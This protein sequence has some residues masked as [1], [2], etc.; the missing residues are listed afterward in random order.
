MKHARL[1]VLLSSLLM[2]AACS[3]GAHRDALRDQLV[4]N[5][6]WSSAIVSANQFDVAASWKTPVPGQGKTHPKTLF[7]YLEGD[8]LAY[9]RPNRASNNPTPDD[10]VGLRMAIADPHSGP[11]LYL[12][13]PCQYVIPDHGRNCARPYW[14]LQRYAPEIVDSLGTTLDIFKTR[15]AAENL[16]LVGYSGGGALAVILAAQRHDVV[17]IVTVA[18]NLDT[19]YWTG[20]DK[21]SPLAG[22]LDPADFATKLGNLPQVH[23][24][25]ANDTTVGPDVTR[26]FMA[27]LPKNTPV[28]AITVPDFTHFCCWARD[29]NQLSR[30]T[31]LSA[32]PGWQ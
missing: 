32:I 28:S 3:H 27:R 18:G 9:I 14:T 26:A 13:R 23:F 30:R 15:L 1:I 19:S 4:A 20:R 21:L 17:G 6:G 25:G 10:P 29:W 7:V 31:E 8:G 24:A 5:A 22:S 2:L 12:A 16:V 11:V